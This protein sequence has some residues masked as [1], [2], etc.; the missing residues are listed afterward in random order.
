MLIYVNPLGDDWMDVTL[1]EFADCK[2]NLGT[3]EKCDWNFSK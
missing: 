2:S 3:S 1:D